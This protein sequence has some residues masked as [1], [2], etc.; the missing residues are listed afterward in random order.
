MSNEELNEKLRDLV[1]WVRN[2][3]GQDDDVIENAALVKLNSLLR[4]WIE[5]NQL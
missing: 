3:P 1:R 5:T 4:Q 2:H